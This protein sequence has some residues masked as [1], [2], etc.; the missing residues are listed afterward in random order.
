MVIDYYASKTAR[1]Q[2]LTFYHYVRDGFVQTMH[3]PV[4][5]EIKREGRTLIGSCPLYRAIFMMI[6]V[7]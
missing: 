7:F 5:K 6:I 4:Y 1:V 2:R 3:A